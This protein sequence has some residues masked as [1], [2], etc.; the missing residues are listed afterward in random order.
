MLAKR[1]FAVIACL[2]LAA[3]GLPRGAGFT[4]EVLAAA[5][6]FAPLPEDGQLYGFAQYDVNRHTL[7]QLRGW[8]SRSGAPLP[9]PIAQDQPASLIITAGDMVQLTVWDAE[10]N[11]VFDTAAFAGLPPTEVDPAGRVFVP[12]IGELRVAGMAP[13]TA[14]QRIEEELAR[15]VPSVQVQ[16]VVEPGGGNTAN[17]SGGVG[18]PGLYPIPQ[19]NYRLLDLFTQ[20]GGPD[21]T[22]ESPQVRL[23]RNGQTFG[24]PYEQLSANPNLNI[25]V[26][27]GD[28]IFVIDDE[29]QFIALGATGSQSIIDF[30]KAE[31][32]ALEA[33]ASIGGV[34]A[35]TANPEKVLILREYEP[36]EVRDGITGPPQERVVF[37]IDLTHA[38]G[39]FSAGRFMMEDGDLIYGTE[40]A[41]GPFL[42]ALG[43]TNTVSG[44]L[45]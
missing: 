11:S 7:P 16:L 30:P 23:V 17:L 8:G 20:A 38:D 10:E 12:F 15:T 3:C 1:L 37:I 14:R 2:A 40:S 35:G 33:I 31:L 18:A 27:G 32:S 5:N 41:L 36:H 34:S 24:I 42:A 28:R 19:R 44:A 6:P 13:S 43:L 21:A 4:S 29:R 22:F 45:N 25:P 39:L 26:R 9:W